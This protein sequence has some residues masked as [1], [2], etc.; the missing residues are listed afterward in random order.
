MAAEA[1]VAEAAVAAEAK[2]KANDEH[3]TPT[4]LS[5]WSFLIPRVI[6]RGLIL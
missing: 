5:S 1:P 4:L 3:Q 2:L 6:C